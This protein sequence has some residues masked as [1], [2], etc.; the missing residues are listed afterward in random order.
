LKASTY[1][2]AK[3]KLE[4]YEIFIKSKILE[5]RDLGG[6]NYILLNKTIDTLPDRKNKNNRGIYI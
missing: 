3:L 4:I 5:F 1:L 6:D 2:S